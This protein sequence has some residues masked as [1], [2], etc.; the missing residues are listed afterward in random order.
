[1]PPIA[2]AVAEAGILLFPL[3][4]ICAVATLLVRFAGARG[5]ERQQ[6]KSFVYA[7]VVGGAVFL[8]PEAVD[9]PLIGGWLDTPAGSA[10][11][12]AFLP[13]AVAVGIGVA[14]L[15]HGLYDIDRII[16]RTVVYAGVT[17]V[18]GLGYSG[19][20][21][22]SGHLLGAD[23]HVPAWMI[24]STTLAAAAVFRP[25][26]RAIQTRVE[27]KFNRTRYDMRKTI[28]EFN[29]RLRDEVAFATVHEELIE[30]IQ[31]TLQ[32][33]TTVLWLSASTPATA[34]HQQAPDLSTDGRGQRANAT[35]DR[36]T[37]RLPKDR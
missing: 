5:R 11:R 3:A 30:V 23:Q 31:Q 29:Q 13:V 33:T 32:P 7:V 14:I 36:T 26:R 18:L 34:E 24:A 27:R 10:V 8:L 37:L 16:S 12:W 4:L 9:I 19:V 17:A 6:L 1:M 22:L 25:V 15:R 35:P 28:D 21:L 2:A 20:V